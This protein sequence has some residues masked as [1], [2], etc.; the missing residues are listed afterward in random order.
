MSDI[1][2]WG[3][4]VDYTF[5]T[6]DKWRRG[7]GAQAARINT[8]H[9]TNEY[10]RSI[11]LSNISRSLVSE[12][13]T[14]LEEEKCHKDS[15]IN[16]VTSA[17]SQCL[18]WCHLEGVSSYFPPKFQRRE[19]GEGVELFF[20]RNEVERL[21]RAS[22]DPFGRDD[23]ADL[24]IFS[25][26]MGTRVS[27][28]LKMKVRD[29]DLGRKL[30]HIGGRPDVQTKAK[31]HRA[32]PIHDRCIQVLSSRLE[33]TDPQMSVF[34]EEW[35]SR[36]MVSKTFNKIRN[37]CGIGTDYHEDNPYHWHVLRHTYGTWHAEAGTP[38]R[39]LMKLMGHKRIDTTLRYAKA[40]DESLKKAQAAI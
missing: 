38:M 24:I 35:S 7:G 12:F 40:T 29:V 22:R 31:N 28:T 26:F 34:G 23:L 30:V 5:R 9:F 32:I 39:T 8:N 19:E 11:K 37:Y 15:T 14:Y 2:T 27:E 25:V 3:S 18:K 33:G 36:F 10:G 4:A 17:I 20:Q 1:R 13:Q 21:I 16:R 6:Y